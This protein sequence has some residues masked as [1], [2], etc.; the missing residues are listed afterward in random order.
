MVTSS[1]TN[2]TAKII[3]L[4][5]GGYGKIYFVKAKFAPLF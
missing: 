3:V 5:W 1:H 2:K 4:R